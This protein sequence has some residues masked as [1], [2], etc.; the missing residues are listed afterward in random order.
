[1]AIHLQGKP[2]LK[3]FTLKFSPIYVQSM[4]YAVILFVNLQ[5]I[6]WAMVHS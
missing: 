6:Q 1:M 2:S 3:F 5:K 4:I